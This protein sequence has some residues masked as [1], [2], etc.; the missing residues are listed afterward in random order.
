MKVNILGVKIDD[1]SLNQ[2]VELVSG[3]I[4]GGGHYYIATPNP[5]FIVAAY[6]DPDFK[7]ILNKAD[8]AI[9]DGVGLKITGRIKNTTTGVDLMEAL[10]HE[11]A[12]KGWNV[13]LIGGRGVAKLAAKRLRE[14]YH[15][16]KIVIAEDGPE[17]VAWGPA[18]L[19]SR[20]KRASSVSRRAS[21]L[22]AT[23][24][25]SRAEDLSS[26]SPLHNL[27]HADLL[28]V[29]LGMGKQ[30]RWIVESMKKVES[31]VFMGVGGAF[32]Y[33]SG[34]VKRAPIWMRKLGLEWLF[35]LIV[36]PWRIKRQ[37]N[38]LKFIS[39]LIIDFVSG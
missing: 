16:L 27:T 9:P 37:V 6:S 26:L 23:S 39:L 38:L 29:A 24:L 17:M 19:A 5:E 13:G 11:A 12:K 28:F 10:C 32:D 35:R 33:I 21:S 34:N 15:G 2:A 30:E 3:W 7:K 20:S 1:V 14:K 22:V 4:K 36:Q 18:R 8:L 25:R 31:C